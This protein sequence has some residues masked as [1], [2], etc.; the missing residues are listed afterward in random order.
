MA[1]GEKFTRIAVSGDGSCFFHAVA[2]AVVSRTRPTDT[3]MTAK[4]LDDLAMNIRDRTVDYMLQSEEIREVLINARTNLIS[5]YHTPENERSAEA[6][7]TWME[8]E[9]TAWD[10]DETFNSD[11][12]HDT[13]IS[14]YAAEYRKR[15]VYENGTSSF[16][17][18]HF[19]AN[20]YDFELAILKSASVEQIRQHLEY[21]MYGGNRQKKT[22]QKV[23]IVINDGA[24][25]EPLGWT[26]EKRIVMS[27]GDILAILNDVP[28][29]GKICTMDLLNP[30][31]L[32]MAER[33]Y[34]WRVETYD[35]LRIARIRFRNLACLPMLFAKTT[36]RLLDDHSLDSL[37][38]SPLDVEDLIP[39]DSHPINSHPI[40]DVVDSVQDP[41][42]VTTHNKLLFDK[43]DKLNEHEKKEMMRFIV[44]IVY[45]IDDNDPS[46]ARIAFLVQTKGI[47]TGKLSQHIQTRQDLSLAQKKEQC[48]VWFEDKK[49]NEKLLD[50]VNKALITSDIK[51]MSFPLHGEFATVMCYAFV[52]ERPYINSNE[53]N[54]KLSP[55]KLYVGIER[56]YIDLLKIRALRFIDDN[57]T[58]CEIV[59]ENNLRIILCQ[60][61][62]K[63]LGLCLDKASY[64]FFMDHV[65][66]NIRNFSVRKLTVNDYGEY[67]FTNKKDVLWENRPTILRALERDYKLTVDNLNPVLAI[68]NTDFYPATY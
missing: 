51:A 38:F 1:S 42:F 13:F 61:N 44:T 9:N 5:I 31:D 62:D 29:S 33:F 18:Q 54:V 19:I 58:E 63:I 35:N 45:N 66:T 10:I 41:F 60:T 59:Y 52:H 8:I 30:V 50:N 15:K 17:V 53:Q 39:I 26:S 2:K 3:N 46:Y 14:K 43:I 68:L 21:Y 40:E 24:H 64:R 25:F 67:D 6:K 32:R 20:E 28:V 27:I 48:L 12:D 23:A 49:I 4:E 57:T 16:I 37:E 11:I 65:L 47:A 36:T 7:E 55:A 56:G 34:H 22:S